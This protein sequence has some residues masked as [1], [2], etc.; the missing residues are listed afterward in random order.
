MGLE[1]FSLATKLALVTGGGTEIGLGIS[2]ALIEA[3]PYR[4]VTWNTSFQET[5]R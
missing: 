4:M 2:K 1:M 3:Y 5:A